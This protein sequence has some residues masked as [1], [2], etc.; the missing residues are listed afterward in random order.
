[1]RTIQRKILPRNPRS[2]NEWKE[3]FREQ[4]LGIP[5]EVVL[6]LE[7]LKN[8]TG[9]C[10]KFLQADVLVECMESS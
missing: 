9:K 8:A 7:V 2:K 10:R 5:R 4:K 6:F 3:N 1:M